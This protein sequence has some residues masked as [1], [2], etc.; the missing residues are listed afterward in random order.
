[1]DGR[2][3]ESVTYSSH[4]I[5]ASVAS[6]IE[7][8]LAAQSGD[9][10]GDVGDDDADDDAVSDA[11]SDSFFE[12]EPQSKDDDDNDDDD[13]PAPATHVDEVGEAHEQEED[14]GSFF[15]L[16]HSVRLLISCSA[17]GDV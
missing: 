2:H 3:I 14:E 4:P 6:S 7:V 13:M 15:S 12:E 9:E 17:K 16:F 11:S 8:V 10:E 5:P 1:M